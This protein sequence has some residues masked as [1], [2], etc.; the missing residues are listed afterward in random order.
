MGDASGFLYILKLAKLEGHQ[1]QL[2][3]M[4]KVQ[5]GSHKIVSAKWISC[6]DVKFVTMTSN[7]DLTVYEML[8]DFEDELAD[9]I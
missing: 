8:A 9:S 2:L 3:Y 4:S 1:D 5:E 6:L 7:G